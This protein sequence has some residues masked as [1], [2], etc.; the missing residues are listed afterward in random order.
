MEITQEEYARGI[1]LE[2][3]DCLLHFIVS[4]APVDP[5][6]VP[7]VYPEDEDEDEGEGEDV[8]AGVPPPRPVSPIM[9]VVLGFTAGL[10]IVLCAGVFGYAFLSGRGDLRVA[11][12]PRPAPPPVTRPTPPVV[13]PPAPQPTLQPP[14]E[15]AGDSIVLGIGVMVWGMICFAS[16][17]YA[18]MVA[19][20]LAWLARDAR[21][22]GAE[23][24]IWVL[25]V[26][27]TGPVGLLAYLAGRPAGAL[28]RCRRCGSQRLAAARVCP[29]CGRKAGRPRDDRFE[30]L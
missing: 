6:S 14:R 26:V 5:Q 29:H 7:E 12:T 21:A 17:G 11:D 23:G 8:A 16:F 19:V 22:R 28:V 24:G 3:A 15:A 20:L 13:S 9:P 18:V 27:A 10:L 25:A 2:C 1:H 4:P 30:M